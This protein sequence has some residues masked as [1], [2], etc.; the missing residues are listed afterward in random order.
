[1]KTNYSVYDEYANSLIISDTIKYRRL[2]LW[3]TASQS[4]GKRII[5]SVSVHTSAHTAKGDPHSMSVLGGTPP[6]DTSMSC[7]SL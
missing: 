7:F 5:V 3:E 4:L 6:E 1:M 2:F